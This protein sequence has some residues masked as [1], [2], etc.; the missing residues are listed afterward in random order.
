MRILVDASNLAA[1]GPEVLLN[2]M[3][4]ALA[5]HAS[6]DTFILLLPSSYRGSDRCYPANVEVHRVHR[7]RIREIGRIADI[8]FRLRRVAIRLRADVYFTFGDIGPVALPMPQV[9]YLHQPYMVYTED[10]L[11]R[12]LPPAERLKLRFQRWHF[13]RAA[14]TAAAVVV[15]T[16]VMAERVTRRYALPA[17]RVKVVRPPLP[18]HVRKLEARPEDIQDAAAGGAFDLLFLATYYAHKNHAV[19]PSL[20]GELRRRGLSGKV[21]ILL[22]LDGN[23]RRAEAALLSRLESDRDVV[24]NLGRL[25]PNDAAQR[26]AA[27]HALFLPTLVETFGLIYLEAIAAGKPI[28]TSDRDFAHQVCGDLAGYFDPHCAGSIADAI[29]NLMRYYKEKQERT[30]QARDAQLAKATSTPQQ[31]AIQLHTL[32]RAVA[33]AGSHD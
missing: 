5:A 27:A 7:S 1:T 16:E 25:T 4:P 6:A 29:E 26:L 23:R 24:V 12:A 9:I 20:V 33:A 13:A 21:R 2:N 10:E 11:M 30:V 8:N 28:L 14:R 18:A 17:A 32:F 3:L 22:T 31:N 15:Q 19:L